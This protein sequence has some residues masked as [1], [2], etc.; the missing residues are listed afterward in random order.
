MNVHRKREV[1][2]GCARGTRRTS[3]VIP[4]ARRV[5]EMSAE[6]EVVVGVQPA[7]VF[8]RQEVELET[9][10]TEVG[11]VS[12]SDSH[13]DPRR[14]EVGGRDRHVEPELVEDVGGHLAKVAAKLPLEVE[15][16]RLQGEPIS[17]A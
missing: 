6:D 17:V 9:T 5:M 16:D 12:L 8:H 14:L 3:G 7:V 13:E 1:S 10:V 11:D 2:G 15:E 4:G